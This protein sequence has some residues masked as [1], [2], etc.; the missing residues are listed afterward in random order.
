MT[1]SCC[2]C[3]PVTSFKANAADIIDIQYDSLVVKA[4]SYIE[5]IEQQPDTNER[6]RVG[7]E[8]DAI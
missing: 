5:S 3:P 1:R 6:K 4:S 8:I 7:G 2:C